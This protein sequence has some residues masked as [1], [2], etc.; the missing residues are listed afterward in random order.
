M[1]LGER[2][3]IY[4]Y[5]GVEVYQCVVL[6]PC[7]LES[8]VPSSST[9]RSS[10][11]HFILHRPLTRLS[12]ARVSAVQCSLHRRLLNSGAV[13]AGDRRYSEQSA[14]A[15]SRSET[16]TPSPTLIPKGQFLPW[17]LYYF[18]PAHM[19]TDRVASLF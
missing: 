1:S 13:S 5:Y 10:G 7:I 18:V 14:R 6:C 12:A 15:N 2:C 17:S 8:I 16:S 11:P 3:E 19:P 4:Y 9:S